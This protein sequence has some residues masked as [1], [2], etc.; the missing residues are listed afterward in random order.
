MTELNA[1]PA[2]GLAEPVSSK[3]A[4][5]GIPC[6][7][8][9]H[10]CD[11]SP[12]HT[13]VHRDV[14]QRGDHSC[15]WDTPGPK[16][17]PALMDA[18]NRSR[19]G[20]RE[21]GQIV[22]FL[23]D[24]MKDAFQRGGSDPI[25]ALHMLGNHLAEALVSDEDADEF[26]RVYRA[27]EQRRGE[28]PQLRA[29]LEQCRSMLRQSE[30]TAVDLKGQVE[31]QRGLDEQLLAGLERDEAQVERLRVEQAAVFAALRD[32]LGTSPASF[33]QAAAQAVKAIAE[34]D[35]L[36]GL[37]TG[38]ATVTEYGVHF[39]SRM[40]GKHHVDDCRSL[41]DALS[42][43][44]LIRRKVDA[45][46]LLVSRQVPAPGPVGEWRAVSPDDA[47]VAFET[48]KAGSR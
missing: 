2:A 27:L 12:K 9:P 3:R 14:Q 22:V 30:R 1:Q 29:D 15:E 31:C 39:W 41:A 7:K 43:I 24:L 20:A 26:N 13:G 6:L 37:L 47:A 35:R 48:A 32:A 36:A 23:T 38:K 11:R 28:V 19:S 4:R 21:L 40:Y 5:C 18:L 25:G 16:D 8:H 10:A 33:G 44:T 46:A 45:G 42:L 17:V 34:R